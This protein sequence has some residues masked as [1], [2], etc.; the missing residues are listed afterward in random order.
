VEYSGRFPLCNKKTFVT[1]G[2]PMTTSPNDTVVTNTAGSITDAQGNVW[3]LVQTPNDGLRVAVNGQ[4]DT[5][6]YFVTKLEAYWGN[7]YQEIIAND[8]WYKTSVSS[9]W[10]PSS[11]LPPTT[12]ASPNGTTLTSTSGQITDA[13]GNTWSLVSTP[14]EGQQVAL[15]GIV[16]PSYNFTAYVTKLEYLNG[17]IYQ[18]NVAGNWWLQDHPELGPRFRRRRHRPAQTNSPG[19]RNRGAIGIARSIGHPPRCHPSYLP[20]STPPPSRTIMS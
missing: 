19:S 13:A 1:S 18:Q 7:V 10:T 16:D 3:S 6:T 12:S 9:A 17:N 14:N 11:A 5:S 2:P 20:T 4:V 8:W 15:N